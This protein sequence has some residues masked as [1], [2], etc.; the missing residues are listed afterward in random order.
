MASANPAAARIAS[1]PLSELDRHLAADVPD[2][3]DAHVRELTR[4]PV[5]TLTAGPC[6]PGELEELARGAFGLLVVDGLIIRDVRLGS[7][8]MSELLGPGD[9]MSEHRGADELLPVEG[10]W[11]ASAPSR[12]AILDERLIPI[13]ERWPRLGAELLSRAAQQTAR[14]TTWRAVVQLPRVEDRL[15]ALFWL[16]AERWGKIGATGV[17]VPLALTHEMLGRLVGAQRPTVSLAL[18]D[19]AGE[20]LIARREDGAWVLRH[21]SSMRL[22]TGREQ[23]PASVATIVPLAASPPMAA[24]TTP[25]QRLGPHDI[26]LLHKR[27]ASLGAEFEARTLAVQRTLEQCEATRDAVLRVRTLRPRA[28]SAGSHR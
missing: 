16:L 23:R 22:A 28:P 14:L 8:V 4:V 3:G 15:L 10:C 17:I 6:P 12:L 27:V 19:L 7:T 9:L 21:D 20:G 13:L 5:L 11:V 18:K 1:L 25:R 26:A 24:G 2:S